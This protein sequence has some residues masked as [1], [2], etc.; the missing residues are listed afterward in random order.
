MISVACFKLQTDSITV[1]NNQEYE[2]IVIYLQEE[3]VL[4]DVKC[5]FFTYSWEHFKKWDFLLKQLKEYI[6][7]AVETSK[8]TIIR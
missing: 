4:L 5:Y 2:N 1:T 8:S 3:A 6:M 7:H